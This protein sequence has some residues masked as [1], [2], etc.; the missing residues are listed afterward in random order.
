MCGTCVSARNALHTGIL[1]YSHRLP[2][3]E[4]SLATEPPRSSRDSGSSAHRLGSRLCRD[5]WRC[6][7]GWARRRSLSLYGWYRAVAFGEVGGLVVCSSVFLGCLVGW[8]GGGS[9]AS[10][11]P[12]GGRLWSFGGT[13]TPMP[14]P[15]RWWSFTVKDGKLGRGGAVAPPGPAGPVTPA[16]LRSVKEVVGREGSRASALVR[17]LRA[18]SGVAPQPKGWARRAAR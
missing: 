13:A 9:L 17:P 4:W 6:G 16:T 2:R 12:L 18:L 3:A 11:G 1:V 10:A 8:V 15:L 7:D 14:P 5:D